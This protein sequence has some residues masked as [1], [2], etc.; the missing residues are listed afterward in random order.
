MR[1]MRNMIPFKTIS[2]PLRKSW[3]LVL[4]IHFDL[5]ATSQNPLKAAT[6]RI[7][8]TTK[9]QKNIRPVRNTFV[10]SIL[11]RKATLS[12]PL[13]IYVPVIELTVF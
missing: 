2:Q 6:Q 10:A 13:T 1:T 5:T 4:F 11:A 12:I 9:T 8:P 7:V 3:N